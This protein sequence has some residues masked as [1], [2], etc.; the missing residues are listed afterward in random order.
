[1]AIFKP[2]QVEW[3][4]PGQLAAEQ[5]QRPPG[6]GDLGVDADPLGGQQPA[7][8][9]QEG[10]PEFDQRRQRGDRPRRRQ[11]EPFA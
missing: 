10:Q 7:A 11:V 2:E 3:C 8:N 6:R 9:A 5:G 1:M 4:R